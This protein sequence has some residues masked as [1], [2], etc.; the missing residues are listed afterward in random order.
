M[1]FKT[2]EEDLLFNLRYAITSFSSAPPP[3][4]DRV[5]MEAWKDWLAR[6][7]FEHLQRSGW[8]FKKKEPHRE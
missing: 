2:P 3:K 8:D 4:K 5:A 6:H 7:V 1:P